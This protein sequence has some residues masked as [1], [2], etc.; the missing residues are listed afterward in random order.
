M[1]GHR[2][3][4]GKL[5]KVDFLDWHGRA[6]RLTSAPISLNRAD[7]MFRPFA[8]DSA[9]MP[10]TC[11]QCPIRPQC[12]VA[13]ALGPMAIRTDRVHSPKGGS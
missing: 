1:E 8:D 12:H 9:M 4:A 2:G 11:L 10:S 3:L 6:G 13:A 5:H 7:D